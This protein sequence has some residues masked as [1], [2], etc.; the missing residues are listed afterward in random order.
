MKELYGAEIKNGQS[1]LD[2]ISIPADRE[3]RKRNLEQAFFGVEMVADEHSGD[4]PL[5][6]RFFYVSHTP[7]RSGDAIIGAAVLA[8][9]ITGRK[10]AEENLEQALNSLEQQVQERTAQLSDA[11]RSLLTEI[12]DRKRGELELLE[13]ENRYRAIYD[14]SPIAIELYDTSG[15]LVDVNTACLELFGVE[16]DQVI[17]NFS[18]FTD[19]NLKDEYKEKLHRGETIQYQVPFSFD[20]VKNL[21]LYPTSK[22]G[23]IWLDVFIT[24]LVQDT[25]SIRGFLV[26]I[27]DITK[28]KRA[29]DA[30]ISAEETYR[31]IF[32][33]SRIGLFRTDIISGLM[34]DAND[35]VAQF[36]GYPDRASLLEHP[37]NIIE[38][39]ADSND[40][41]K[42]VSLLQA[43]GEFQNFETR[44]R[45]SDETIAWL[46]FSAKLIWEKGW[47]E[48]VAE[49]ITE[50]KLA[51]EALKE[52]QNTLELALFGSETG[53]WEF[54]IPTS[55]VTV[56]A[57]SAEL[58]GYDKDTINSHISSW[59]ELAHPEDIPLMEK[60]L[61][62]CV[63]G[64]TP[65]L[66]T[67]HRMKHASG[68]WVWIL[69]RGKITKR[70][71]DGTPL[72]ISGTMQDISERKRTQ[73]GL[74]ESEKRYRDM[75][76]INNAVMLII[77]SETTRIIDA[78][79]AALRYYG[80]SRD[81][82]TSM[83]IT[84]INIADP[85]VVKKE[86]TH[87]A[88]NEGMTFNFKHRKKSGE[89]R[90]VEV[91]SGPIVVKGK[92]FLHSIIQD[93]TERKYAE[94]AL[95]LTN[96]K[97]TLL[98]SITRHDIGNELQIIFGYLGLA[99]E[100]DLS[101]KVHEYIEKAH[102]SSL[103]I[104]R[105]IAFTRD[106]EDIGVQC[107]IWQDI[108]AV[109]RRTVQNID[110]QQIQEKIDISGVEVF[111]DPLMEKVFFNLVDNAKRYGETLTC[112]RFSGFE[113]SG[114][115]VII[116]EDDGVGI[117]G[118]FKEKIFN[119]EYYKH[120]GFGLN[121]SREILDIT[122]IT[123]S[124]T[125]VPGKGA[126]FEILVPNGRFRITEE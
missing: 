12:A 51:V 1:I 78:N 67:E 115:Y 30:L 16:R 120:T 13:S 45:K 106:Y 40:R 98:S 112:I 55:S 125:G 6:R 35:A 87:A 5:S 64:K 93:I 54:H 99:M 63:N 126:R 57:R 62:D 50:Y 96:H 110:M 56:D 107:P 25:E 95:R 109:I 36:F 101:P 4:D 80:Y 8:H 114:R 66:E 19:P 61:S 124:E 28:R 116:C 92:V 90:D 121:L 43:N 44:I 65:N 42:M 49:D 15:T 91:F 7:I 47:I 38:R 52:S 26:Q 74:I 103:N 119:R 46:R 85:T 104:E 123:I 84:Q 21:N 48:G 77:D 17:E 14:K 22:E 117:P 53:M 102:L 69:G 88:G 59:F 39:Y 58:L 113:N 33:N 108:A 37:F 86:I 73:E 20:K 75:F 81:E 68:E 70:L 83:Y 94:E 60:R 3:T 71:S 82:I 32:L 11:N 89:I 118:E 31:N 9:D 111:A 24:P 97:L 34:L 41:E 105:Q 76:E 100:K 18:L 10:K 2:Y 29:E 23:T 79:A 72:L 122:G 27:L